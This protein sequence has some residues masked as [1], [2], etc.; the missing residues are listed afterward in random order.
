MKRILTILLAALFVLASLPVGLNAE[1]SSSPKFLPSDYEQLNAF[2]QNETGMP[3]VSNADVI[4]DVGDI[5]Q[6]HGWIYS[7][8]MLFPLQS[9]RPFSKLPVNLSLKSFPS[10]TT[11]GM[12][13]SLLIPLPAKLSVQTLSKPSNQMHTAS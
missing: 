10:N 7:R 5:A 8:I 6:Y 2:L 13:L 3:G 4:F 1:R 11:T 12:G 9:I